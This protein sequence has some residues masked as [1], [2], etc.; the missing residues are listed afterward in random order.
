M[1]YPCPCGCRTRARGRP[2][3]WC[4]ALADY[5][6]GQWRPPPPPQVEV[7]LTQYGDVTQ[8]VV[9]MTVYETVQALGYHHLSDLYT[10]NRRIKG[11]QTLKERAPARKSIPGLGAWLARHSAVSAPPLRVPQPTPPAVAPGYPLPTCGPRTIRTL[12]WASVV[13]GGWRST[14]IG[15]TIPW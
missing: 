6:R 2:P 3:S 15:R 4:G 5:E 10:A 14:R 7:Y 9:P 11:E 12:D 1:M 13:V 8:V